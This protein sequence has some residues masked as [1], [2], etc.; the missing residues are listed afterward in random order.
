M[1]S[2]THPDEVPKVRYRLQ[3]MRVSEIFNK[4]TTTEVSPAE[5]ELVPLI[6]IHKIR[7]DLLL[8][9]V[10]VY[11]L[12]QAENSQGLRWQNLSLPL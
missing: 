11:E 7:I 8:D 1:T 2:Q 9:G 3:G 5:V 6:S 4:I 12:S 10:K